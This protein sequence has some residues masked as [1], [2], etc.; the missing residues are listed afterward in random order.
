MKIETEIKIKTEIENETN[1]YKIG[2]ENFNIRSHSQ[3][4]FFRDRNRLS[5]IKTAPKSRPCPC[6]RVTS[7]INTTQ[8]SFNVYQLI[9]V[10]S[11][12]AQQQFQTGKE[13]N[14]ILE[15]LMPILVL[16]QIRERERK[17]GAW[18]KI[19]PSKVY[20]LAQVWGSGPSLLKIMGSLI[21]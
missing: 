19:Y 11:Q 7:S 21:F 9:S 16:Q 20:L 5:E 4:H 8:E 1:N 12:T 13:Q 2:T 17:W 6:L 18:N 10:K 3:F 15:S 14:Q